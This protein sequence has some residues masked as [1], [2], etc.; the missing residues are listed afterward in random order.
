[1]QKFFHSNK[2][3]YDLMKVSLV[4]FFMAVVFVGASHAHESSG[5]EILNQRVT[6]AVKNQDLEKVL[7]RLAKIAKVHFLYSP[8]L[9][10]ADRKVN[11][12]LHNQ[13]VGAALQELLNP[14][15]LT[16]QV[17][18][19]QVVLKR[20]PAT[21]LVAQNSALAEEKVEESA[22]ETVEDST[23]PQEK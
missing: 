16:Y 18:G 11:L 4:Q 15:D 23:D 3:L 1:M 6:I 9:I 19:E 22:E 17:M 7:S 5:Q 14:L 12:T 8:E 10:A 20:K 2:L 21:V 13:S